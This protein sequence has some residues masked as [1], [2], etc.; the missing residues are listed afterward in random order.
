[1]NWIWTKILAALS[2]FSHISYESGFPALVATRDGGILTSGERIQ[3]RRPELS[4][5]WSRGLMR[6]MRRSV[7]SCN[8]CDYPHYPTRRVTHNKT[9]TLALWHHPLISSFMTPYHCCVISH[10]ASGHLRQASN[11]LT[12]H[13]T[14]CSFIPWYH[15][16]WHPGTIPS[17]HDTWF[18]HHDI[19]TQA[20]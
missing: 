6:L 1:M 19:L 7:A 4:K 8:S 15:H 18:H 20:Y 9:P 17:S 16:T 14:L 11:S 13:N 12:L 10:Q 3:T 2:Q 5:N